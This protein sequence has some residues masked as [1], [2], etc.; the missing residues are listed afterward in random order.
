MCTTIFVSMIT[1]SILTAVIVLF[2][3]LFALCVSAAPD[4]SLLLS[5]EV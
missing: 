2:F 4:I 1:S 3:M 5:L